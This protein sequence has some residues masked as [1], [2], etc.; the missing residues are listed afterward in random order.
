MDWLLPLITLLAL[1]VSFLRSLVDWVNLRHSRLAAVPEEFRS[2]VSQEK[3]QEALAYLE[4][5]TQFGIFHRTF[6]TVVGLAFLWGGGFAYLDR[7][8]GQWVEAAVLRGLLYFALLGVLSEILSIP[9]SWY[10]T[11]VL[12][13][14][15]NRLTLATFATDQ[16]KGWLLGA[17]LGAAVIG[18]ILWFFQAAGSLG[19]LW[20]WGFVAL[21]QLVLGFLAPV[22]LMPLFNRFTPLPEGE[23]KNEIERYAS[24]VSF[25]LQGIF[26]M[27]GSKRSSKANAFFTG[28]GRFRRIV[29]FDTLIQKHTVPE[30]VARAG[31]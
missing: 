2:L 20:A 1:T 19:W 26:T 3:Q 17:V 29:L 6:W 7:L 25:K 24:A 9:F 15:F 28:L 13:K 31:P 21:F 12:E 8:A 5:Q 27:D 14:K 16:L 18:G 30:L 4:A 22:L 23:L 11:F 10:S